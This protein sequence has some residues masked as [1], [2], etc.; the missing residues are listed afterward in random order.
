MYPLC[1][2]P[3]RS[4]A[5]SENRDEAASCK[6]GFILAFALLTAGCASLPPPDVSDAC[7]I[8]EDRKSWYDAA[9]KARDRWN[10]PPSLTLAFI[11][12]ESSF[13]AGAKPPRTKL[14]GFIPWK[15]KTSARGYAQAIDATWKQ[16]KKETGNRFARRSSFKYAVDFI[17]WYNNK[18][19]R[20]LGISPNDAYN[21]YLAYHEGWGGYRKKSYLKKEKKWLIGVA[22]KVAGRKRVYEKQLESCAGRLKVP[23]YRLWVNAETVVPAPPSRGRTSA[24]ISSRAGNMEPRRSHTL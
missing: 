6:T 24:K 17:G 18:S 11:H 15:R 7:T 1:V 19:V 8:L 21:L 10:L 12:Q 3:A 16:Y 4:R 23:W 9:L 5:R 14:L 13:K 22:K 20:T 2:L